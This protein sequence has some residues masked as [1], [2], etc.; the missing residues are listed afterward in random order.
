MGLWWLNYITSCWGKTSAGHISELAV[1]FQT[2]ERH[3]LAQPLAKSTSQ[4][5]DRR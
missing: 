3:L 5:L 1:L 2:G 4:G